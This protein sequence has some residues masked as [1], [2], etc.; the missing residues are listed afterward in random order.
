MS[1]C[2]H[3]CRV[4]TNSVLLDWLQSAGQF[5]LLATEPPLNSSGL[6]HLLKLCLQL[7]LS[8]FIGQVCKTWYG[9][10]GEEGSGYAKDE[11]LTNVVV[12]STEA[13]HGWCWRA[14]MIYIQNHL[15]FCTPGDAAR[16][17]GKWTVAPPSCS[18]QWWIV[19]SRPRFNLCWFLV[20][21]STLECCGYTSRSVGLLSL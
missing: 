13:G 21:A 20:Y 8:W 10:G 17:K 7:V 16:K 18:D 4:L 15:I 19:S 14:L 5:G 3:S 11:G 9:A 1:G 6:I 2:M 12:R